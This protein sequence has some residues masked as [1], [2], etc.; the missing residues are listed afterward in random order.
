MKNRL[1]Y[2]LFILLIIFPLAEIACRIVGYR[3]YEQAEYKIT[4]QPT[5][6]LIGDSTFG[7]ALNPGRCQV[8]INNH[9]TYRAT[10]EQNGRRKTSGAQAKND[11]SI[12]LMGC[13]FTYGMGVNDDETFA[14][15]LQKEHPAINIEN[16]GVP[17]FGTTQ[18]ILQLQAEIRKRSIP[19][20]VVLHFSKLHFDR[21]AL[22][23][24]FRSD[25][26]VGFVKSGP[27]HRGMSNARFPY[28]KSP[29]AT[30]FSWCTWD[31]LYP[32]WSGRNT[33]ALVN[34]LALNRERNTLKKMDVVGISKELIL[35]ISE[36]CEA[37]KIPFRICFLDDDVKIEELRKIAIKNDIPF[38]NV[39]LRHTDKKLTQLPYDSHPNKK[40]HQ[41]IAKTIAPWIRSIDLK[42]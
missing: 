27:H 5:N 37:N 33:F 31:Q 7:F 20:M 15:I 38:K 9:V 14:S 39:H 19:K 11:H 16:F 21:N 13:S 41:L 28:L 34:F 12:F 32:E 6:C 18:S 4:A 29:K 10:H 1:L 17:G 25:L 22:T 35:Q 40:G 8:T 26:K 36:L 23:P 42:K 30:S 24:Q 2:A 3:P